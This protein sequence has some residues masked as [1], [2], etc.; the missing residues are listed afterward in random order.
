MRTISSCWA[1]SRS[2]V[3]EEGVDVAAGER[4]A[5]GDAAPH[6]LDAQAA[7]RQDTNGVLTATGPSPPN[8]GK[9]LAASVWSAAAKLNPLGERGTESDTE[10]R[11]AHDLPAARTFHDQQG[12]QHDDNGDAEGRRLHGDL[13]R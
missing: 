1:S 10:Q 3:V 8:E 4:A 6:R 13:S 7:Q 2:Q 11:Q 5:D 9:A 12:D